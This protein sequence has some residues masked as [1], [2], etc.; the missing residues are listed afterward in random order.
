MTAFDNRTGEPSLDGALEYALE[1]ELSNS[2]FVNIVPRPRIDDALELMRKPASTHVD[3][4]V[5][6]EVALRDGRIKAIIAGRVEKIGG[7]YSVSVRIASPVDGAT[8]A[9]VNEASVDQKDLVRVIGRVAVGLRKKLGE[10]LPQIKTEPDQLEKVTTPSMRALQLYSQARALAG[11]GVL[12]GTPTTPVAVEQLLSDALVED[13]NFVWAH[14]L[15]ARALL[16]QGRNVEALKHVERAATAAE[17][18]GSERYIATGALH[19]LRGTLSGNAADRTRYLEQATASFEAAL[20][21]QPDHAWIMGRLMDLT[22]MLGRFPGPV[23]I[24]R[25]LAVRPNSVIVFAKAMNAAI[26]AG[27]LALAR[28]YARRGSALDVLIDTAN[29][30]TSNAAANLRM[31]SVEDALYRRNP[32]Q[33]LLEADRLAGDSRSRARGVVNRMGLKLADLYLALGRLD[34]VEEVASWV[35]PQSSGY[36]LLVIASMAREDRHALR[37]LLRRLFP[38]LEN[39]L[40]GSGGLAASA[41]SAF[42]N[43]GLFD[44]AQRLIAKR[45]H[46]PTFHMLLE[47]ELALAQGRVTYGVELLER[48]LREDAPAEAWMRIRGSLRTCRFLDSARRRESSC[49]RPGNCISRTPPPFRGSP[50]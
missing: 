25:Y 6:R 19:E 33:A 35:E 8:A 47:G 14:I 39:V 21:L 41:T 44:S 46:G 15:M 16:A 38:N 32:E 31:F 2:S 27:N 9:I 20:Q 37:L 50:A 40:G 49:R 7:A 4:D 42:I 18:G 45:T 1:R 29:G 28:D 13:P 17:P 3:A 48:L 5:G 30:F 34:R 22:E 12:L 11:D 24:E 26:A 23:F 10:A 43:A 36:R